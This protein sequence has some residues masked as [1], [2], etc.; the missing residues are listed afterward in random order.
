M[1]KTEILALVSVPWALISSYVGLF[2]VTW[3]FNGL[4]KG[5]IY[6]LFGYKGSITR[7]VTKTES[8]ALVSLR[9]DT[10]VKPYGTILGDITVY[11]IWH[12]LQSALELRL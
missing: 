6:D 1:T 4:F 7:I 3:Q 5:G 11:H 12:N 2:F 10:D 8:F 9:L